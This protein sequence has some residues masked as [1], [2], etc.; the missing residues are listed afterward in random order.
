[1]VLMDAENNFVS[2]WWKGGE[3]SKRPSPIHSGGVN[4]LMA[5]GHVRYIKYN[6]IPDGYNYTRKPEWKAFWAYNTHY[7]IDI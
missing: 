2:I 1:M 4:A 3:P 6:S 5:D 7:A